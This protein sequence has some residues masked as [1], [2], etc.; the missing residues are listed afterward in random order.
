MLHC[1]FLAVKWSSR[2]LHSLKDK[3]KM[4]CLSYLPKNC[5]GQVAQ[6]TSALM[7]NISQRNQSYFLRVAL[8]LSFIP[9]SVMADEE[10]YPSET[11]G[12]WAAFFDDDICWI[13]SHPKSIDGEVY[14]DIF[15]FISFFNG[16]NDFE[17][18]L[19]SLRFLDAPT[20]A[21][22]LVGKN[23]YELVQVDD[24]MYPSI[25]DEQDLFWDIFH[26]SHIKLSFKIGRTASTSTVV[27]TVGFRNAYQY[28]V[29]G[30]NFYGYGLI[31]DD[32]YK[33]PT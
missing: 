18:S 26:R 6:L 4:F 20:R 16:A 5:I 25:D 28:I 27:S 7:A 22:I 13:G 14:E 19:H 15:L 21:D 17:I 9:I 2:A 12:N 10:V 32:E 29:D 23:A 3:G 1:N 8:L 30:C 11:Y 31:Y 24:R 33:E